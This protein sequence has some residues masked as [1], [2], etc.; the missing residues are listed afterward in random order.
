[1][2][3]LFPASSIKASVLTK[4]GAVLL[5]LA[6]S[7]LLA[8]AQMLTGGDPSGGLTLN[9]AN[10]I[11]AIYTPVD[12][13]NLQT[14]DTTVFQGVT[15]TGSNSNIGL[16]SVG[17]SQIF[18]GNNGGDTATNAGFTNASSPTPEDDNLLNLVN[19]GLDF[20]GNGPPGTTSITLTINNLTGGDSYRIDSIISLLGFPASRDVTIA[21]NGSATPTDDLVLGSG[22]TFNIYDE[23]NIVEAAPDG[24]IQVTYSGSDGGFYSGFVVSAVPEPSTWAL[25][26]PGIGFLGFYLR[27]KSDAFRP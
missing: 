5:L 13:N 27:R 15:F 10:V 7:A 20:S 8:S 21:Y 25:M 22:D 4:F 18:L 16:T 24:T 9:P 6:S 26:L 23:Q 14:S 17:A 19:A 3:K 2:H 12:S 1:M 11:A